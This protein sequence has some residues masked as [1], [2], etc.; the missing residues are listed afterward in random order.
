MPRAVP[1]ALGSQ[2]NSG[3]PVH[4][5]R[6]S[7]QHTI[8]QK[9]RPTEL[10]L[11]PFA[12][13]VSRDTHLV[14]QPSVVEFHLRVPRRVTPRSF[15]N[16]QPGPTP[17]N[18]KLRLPPR[19]SRGISLCIRGD[20]VHHESPRPLPCL[21]RVTTESEAAEPPRGLLLL[22]ATRARFSPDCRRRALFAESCVLA[23]CPPL[24]TTGAREV[25]TSL[26]VSRTT[27][28]AARGRQGVSTISCRVEADSVI[29]AGTASGRDLSCSPSSGWRT[30][31]IS[32]CTAYLRVIRK[33]SPARG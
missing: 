4:P 19:Q 16:P 14:F 8:A 30:K 26:R 9:F 27:T 13:T 3:T 6:P 25:R 24:P 15:T 5:V 2:H 17:G 23:S 12:R 1:P 32:S 10:R 33:L 28:S 29:H 18:V 20:L 21:G 31:Q 7:M 22:A 11:S